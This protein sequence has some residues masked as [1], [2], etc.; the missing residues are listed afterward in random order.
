MTETA[1]NNTLKSKL[2]S[3]R[4]SNS[5]TS[6]KYNEKAATSITSGLEKRVLSPLASK[7][8]VEK[9]FIGRKKFSTLRP[10]N[11]DVVLLDPFFLSGF[12]DAEGCFSI[13]ISKHKTCKTGYNVAA[14]FAIHLHYKDLA[15]L[16]EI[17]AFLGVGNIYINK[18][19]V[20]YSVNS[21]KE[22]LNVII[23]FF[24]RYPFL[25]KKGVD[26]KLFK[27]IVYML[28][29]KEHLTLEGLKKI[30]SLRASLNLGLS[31]QLKLDFPDLAVIPRP[32]VEPIKNIDLS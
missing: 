24:D 28:N 30:L 22:I 13:G 20:R 15:L 1:I 27:E 21:H 6:F 4:G 9:S 19:T 26:F 23:P 17:Q 12:I 5:T 18:N 25:S 32:S 16:K 3:L 7:K 8:L 2:D 11:L 31:E 29:N 10:N 14:V